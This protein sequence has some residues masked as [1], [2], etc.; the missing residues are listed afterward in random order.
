MDGFDLLI[1][2]PHFWKL[3]AVLVVWEMGLVMGIG[4]PPG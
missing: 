4:K 1:V 3:S 2:F